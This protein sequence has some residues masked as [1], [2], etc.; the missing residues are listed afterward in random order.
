MNLGLPTCYANKL[1]WTQQ[2]GVIKAT[3][4]RK[5][6]QVAHNVIEKT[7]KRAGGSF[8]NNNGNWYFELVLRP[9]Q[10]S[11]SAVSRAFHEIMK[12]GMFT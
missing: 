12:E 3:P 2:N 5:L 9:R 7:F 10:E 1:K 6:S 4:K 11:D 8:V